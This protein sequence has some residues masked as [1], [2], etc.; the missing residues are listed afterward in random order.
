MKNVIFSQKK[1]T[2]NIGRQEAR[3][4]E[5]ERYKEGRRWVGD[6]AG[7]E[8]LRERRWSARKEGRRRKRSEMDNFVR[9]GLG[10]LVHVR[11]IPKMGFKKFDVFF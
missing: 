3:L 5:M 8:N 1:K 2:D 7:G 9:L 6:G 11:L 4:V 10:R